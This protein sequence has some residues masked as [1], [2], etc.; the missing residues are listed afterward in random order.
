MQLFKHT[1]VFHF[2]RLNDRVT[3]TLR[4]YFHWRGSEFFPASRRLVWL[5]DHATNVI[6][7]SQSSKDARGEFG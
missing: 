7:V 2:F 5:S 3:Q 4:Q 6:V 1:W